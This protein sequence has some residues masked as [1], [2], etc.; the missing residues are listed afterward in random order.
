M[1]PVEEKKAAEEKVE[2]F[3]GEPDKVHN[4]MPQRYQ[5]RSNTNMVNGVN[6]RR[7][8]FYGQKEPNFIQLEGEPERSGQTTLYDEYGPTE[9]VQNLMPRRYERSANSNFVDGVRVSRTT[10]YTQLEDDVATPT[11]GVALLEPLAYKHAADTN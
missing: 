10:Y 4:L 9:K 11:E 3:D 1:G 7:T 5:L 8:T 2:D 6:V